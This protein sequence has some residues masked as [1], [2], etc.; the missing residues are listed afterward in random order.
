M[1]ITIITATYN[2]SETIKDCIE[3]VNNQ[4][5]PEIEHII[6]DGGSKDNTIQIIESLDNRVKLVISEPDDGLYYAMNKGILHASGEIVGILNS[7]DIYINNSVLERVMEVF[8]NTGTDCVYADLF[9]VDSVNTDKIVRHWKTSQYKQG[10]FKKG[11]HPAHP[12]FFLRNT[13]YKKYGD[14][15]LSFILAADFELMLRMLEKHHITSQYIPLPLV[16]MRFG[17]E[18]N[19]N[20][21]NIWNQ[22]IE[23]IR[24]FKKNDLDS[25]F[26]YPFYRLIPKLSQYFNKY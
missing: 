12:S 15:D 14:F 20:I 8:T 5:Y 3:S 7:D 18:S 25:G 13:V 9:Y 1:T 16:K 17:G 4:T 11:W 10:A 2:S 24:A 22:N 6:I 23:C 21:S 26:L 19:R